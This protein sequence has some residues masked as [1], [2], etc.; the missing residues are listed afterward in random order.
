MDEFERVASSLREQLESFFEPSELPFTA[1]SNTGL[2]GIHQIFIEGIAPKNATF[3]D[4]IQGQVAP[5]FSKFLIQAMCL[6]AAHLY[7][8]CKA[9]KEGDSSASH[10][11]IAAAEEI[12]FIR[13]M[14]FGVIHED[15]VS[16]AKKSIH[17]KLGGDRRAE[18]NA[19]LKA[20]AISQSKKMV[21]G[22]PTERARRLML[23]VPKEL[24]NSSDNPERIIRETI[25]RELKKTGS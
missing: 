17:G 7:A 22:S 8:G 2:E 5:E 25:S 6:G 10:C 3:A 16:R 15:D 21:R 20:W 19:A 4:H 11:L 9:F 1:F 13:G 23:D 14:A 24:A 12:G 18:K